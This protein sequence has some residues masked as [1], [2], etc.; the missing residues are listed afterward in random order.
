MVENT[1]NIQSQNA[2]TPFST[3]ITL[4]LGNV[5]MRPGSW[6]GGMSVGIHGV[7]LKPRAE[8]LDLLRQNSR[9]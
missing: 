8:N 6:P 9:N 1:G 3:D 7:F 2:D 5:A 4:S